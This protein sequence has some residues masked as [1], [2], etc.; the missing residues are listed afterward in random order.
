MKLL[1]TSE[2]PE[3][4]YSLAFVG[5]GEESDTAVIEHVAGRQRAAW[6]GVSA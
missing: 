1:R 5:Y 6:Y 3:Y 2:N 4:K